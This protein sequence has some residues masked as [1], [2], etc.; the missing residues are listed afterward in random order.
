MVF[1]L[2]CQISLTLTLIES[3]TKSTY[4][5]S[6]VWVWGLWKDLSGWMHVLVERFEPKR[7]KRKSLHWR[8]CHVAALA[9][10]CLPLC[11]STE[12]RAKIAAPHY[13]VGKGYPNL[14]CVIHPSSWSIKAI[15]FYGITASFGY[16]LLYDRVQRTR[17][18]VQ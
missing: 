1:L 2:R 5:F 4:Y 17:L 18:P 6:T 15:M 3:W 9:D 7:A 10:L 13:N 12:M 14:G 16:L 11:H 8:A